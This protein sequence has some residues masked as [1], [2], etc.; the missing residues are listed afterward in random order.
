LIPALLR[1]RQVFRLG[2]QLVGAFE[3]DIDGIP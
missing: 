2:R 3:G 1:Q